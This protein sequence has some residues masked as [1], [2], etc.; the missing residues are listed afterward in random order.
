MTEFRLSPYVDADLDDIAEYIMR[1]NPIR[2]L[3][4]VDE[5]TEKFRVI[6]ERPQSF[7]LVEGCTWPLCSALHGRYRILFEIVEEIPHILRVIH[8]ARDIDSLF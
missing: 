2:A 7:P 1:D 3:S 8:G 4:F 6:G 5:I